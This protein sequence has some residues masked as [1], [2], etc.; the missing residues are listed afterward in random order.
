M[1]QL[2][3]EKALKAFMELREKSKENFPEELLLEEINNEINEA[4]LVLEGL[5]DLEENK[6]CD[7][8]SVIKAI[9]EKYSL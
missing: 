4:R 2:N 1:E 8:P 3:K 5:K 6:I 9:K 7:G